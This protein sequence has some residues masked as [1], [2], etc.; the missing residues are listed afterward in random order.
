M[1]DYSCC[2]TMT[3]GS[4]ATRTCVPKGTSAKCQQAHKKFLGLKPPSFIP[5]CPSCAEGNMKSHSFLGINN[6]GNQVVWLIHLDLKSLPVWILPHTDSV[7]YGLHWWIKSS[8]MWNRANLR[9]N[10][11][12]LKWSR[13]SKAMAI[14][15]HVQPSQDGESIKGGDL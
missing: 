4:K 2:L 3:F 12:H 10:L 9:R 13:T 7:L 14:S 15:Q 5:F 6:L 1:H 11:T 8:H